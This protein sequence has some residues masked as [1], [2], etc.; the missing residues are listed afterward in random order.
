MIM[1]P[2]AIIKNG[3]KFKTKWKFVLSCEVCKVKKEASYKY[4]QL[5]KHKDAYRCIKC[6]VDINRDTIRE[7]MVQ[8]WKDPEYRAMISS[9]ISDAK[10]VAYF[11][12]KLNRALKGT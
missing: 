10:D 11:K 9:K 2:V 12:N 5:I 8:K 3:E 7:N 4:Y 1:E 6:A